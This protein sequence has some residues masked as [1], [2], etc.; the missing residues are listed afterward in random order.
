M[1]DGTRVLRGCGD[2]PAVTE[3]VADGQADEHRGDREQQYG[4]RSHGWVL[5]V[6]TGGV[7]AE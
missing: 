2:A 7:E 4:G 3:D 5:S 1:T 6:E